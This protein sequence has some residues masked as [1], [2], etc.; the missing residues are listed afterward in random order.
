[1]HRFAINVLVH[2]SL[3]LA[4][5]VGASLRKGRVLI[6]ILSSQRTAPTPSDQDP[7][8][9]FVLRRALVRQGERVQRYVSAARSPPDAELTQYG[10]QGESAN[11]T[12]GEVI[13]VLGNMEGTLF[14]LSA[15]YPVNR[16]FHHPDDVPLSEEMSAVFNDVVPLFSVLMNHGVILRYPADERRGS[17]PSSGFMA[18]MQRG[19]RWQQVEGLW[20]NMDMVIPHRGIIPFQMT[21]SPMSLLALFQQ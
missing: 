6:F 3:R 15:Q 12:R 2:S 21:L 8:Q 16:A 17:P 4:G 20:Q 7:A 19:W 11:T 1:M 14:M 13:P 10:Y 5:G 9:E 18:R